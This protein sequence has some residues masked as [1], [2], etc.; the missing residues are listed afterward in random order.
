MELDRIQVIIDDL[1]VEVS[2]ARINFRLD[3][4]GESETFPVV[5]EA[6]APGERSLLGVDPI[7]ISA[8]PTF[9]FLKRERRMIVQNDVLHADLQVPSAIIKSY[10]VGAQMLAPIVRDERLVAILAVA[11]TAGTREWSDA[12]VAALERAAAE[13]QKEFEE[14][15]AR[16]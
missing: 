7:D 8:A 9:L 12:D 15:G 14:D 3:V 11:H 2:A 1:L 16:G 10:G 5:A 13:T 6:L 4:P